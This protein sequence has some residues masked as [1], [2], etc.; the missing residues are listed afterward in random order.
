[1]L[2]NIVYYASREYYSLKK[3]KKIINCRG[4]LIYKFKI[5]FIHLYIN[6]RKNEQ[7]QKMSFFLCA[8]KCLS[9]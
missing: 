3:I 8:P 5:F 9:F 1:M 7:K 4:L 6:S 2:N